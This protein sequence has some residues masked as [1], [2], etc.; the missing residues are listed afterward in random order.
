MSG[1]DDE[2]IGCLAN[3]QDGVV[4]LR[5]DFLG[6]GGQF[7]E[8]EALGVLGL[9]V[10]LGR[11]ARSVHALQPTARICRRFAMIDVDDISTGRV[12]AASK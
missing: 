10:Y 7:V 12:A 11:R 8:I 3:A 4:A 1:Q 6:I 2:A 5:H 9:R